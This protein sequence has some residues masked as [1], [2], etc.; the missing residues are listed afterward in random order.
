MEHYKMENELISRIKGYGLI[1]MVNRM[2]AN[3][4]LNHLIKGIIG[5]PL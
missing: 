2:S 4:P 1:K 3:Q 5:S